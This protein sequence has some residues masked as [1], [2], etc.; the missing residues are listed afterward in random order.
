MSRSPLRRIGA[1]DLSRIPAV[2]GVVT[3]AATL[4]RLGDASPPCDIVELRADLLDPAVDWVPLL[5]RPRKVPLLLTI[6]HQR[7]G[8]RWNGPAPER[9]ARYQGVLEHV[10]AVDIELLAGEFA[11]VAALANRVGKTLIA[12]YHNFE[13]TPRADHLRALISQA[14]ERGADIVKLATW[15]ATA[16]DVDT[17][18]ALLNDKPP[19]PLAVMGMG[20]LGVESRLRLV[21]AGSCLVYGFLDEPTAPG[22]VSAEEWVKRLSENLPAYREARA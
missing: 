21:L 10:E 1:R 16:R 20:P 22:Q 14:A 6:R 12:S 2:V 15:T 11:E 17:L 13:S 19:C 3:R 8:G 4:E 5:Q 18:E 9:A 7:E